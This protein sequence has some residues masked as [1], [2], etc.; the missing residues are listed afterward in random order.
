MLGRASRH[1][2]STKINTS[3]ANTRTKYSAAKIEHGGEHVASKRA[4]RRRACQGKIQFFS[5]QQALVE[6]LRLQ[7]F[8]GVVVHPYRCRFCGQW[9]NG[10][11]DAKTKQ[12]KR[13]I[14]EVGRA[15]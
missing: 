9:H 8:H 10:H 14:L 2:P 5:R 6:A 3:A 11:D 13:N 7:K 4:I 15:R 12:I 1:L